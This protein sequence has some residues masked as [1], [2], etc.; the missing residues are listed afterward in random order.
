MQLIEKELILPPF[1]QTSPFFHTLSHTLILDIETT[2]LSAHRSRLYLIGCLFCTESASAQPRWQLRQWFLD[3][4]ADE[5]PVLREFLT[6]TEGFSHFITFNGATFDLPYLR[7][8]AEQLHIEGADAAF[9]RICA[10]HTDLFRLFRPLKAFLS[11]PDARLKTYERAV[12]IVR[13]DRFSG[14]DLIAQYEDY[15]AEYRAGSSGGISPAGKKL[16]CNLLLHNEEDI[17]NIPLLLSSLTQYSVLFCS[18]LPAVLNSDKLMPEQF[19][20]T[21]LHSSKEAL[22]ICGK[23]ACTLPA[24]AELTHNHIALS[25]FDDCFQLT[26]PFYRG[27]LKYYFTP[28]TDYYYLPDEDMAVHKKIAQYVDPAHRQKA[29][30]QTC[31]TRKSGCFLPQLHE[32][33]SPVF[34]TMYGKQPVVFFEWEDSGSAAE[35]AALTDISFHRWCADLISSFCPPKLS[36]PHLPTDGATV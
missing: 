17:S 16:L 5:L 10:S 6:F 31:Y 25:L 11:L 19:A 3:S 13:E 12:G 15:A 21:E 1:S 2:G 4:Q 35:R 23:T 36:L 8:C 28:Y 7:V 18:L 9:T 26:V 32:L 24:S 27:E 33:I 29:T 34:S 22:T 20:V 30:R 14:F